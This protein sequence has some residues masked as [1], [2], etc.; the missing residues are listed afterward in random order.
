[1]EVKIVKNWGVRDVFLCSNCIL[2][3]WSVRH[4]FSQS[5][6]QSVAEPVGQ[7]VSQSV[8]YSVLSHS[9]SQ[10]VC[11]LLSQPISLSVSSPF[12]QTISQSLCQP[13]TTVQ[14]VIGCFVIHAPSC[15]SH[16][17]NSPIALGN[18]TGN[19]YNVVTAESSKVDVYVYLMPANVWDNVGAKMPTMISLMASSYCQGTAGHWVSHW[20]CK[21]VL[22]PWLGGC[23]LLL[24]H[25]L[26]QDDAGADREGQVLADCKG[27]D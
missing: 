1:M 9:V 6:N 25:P 15:A 18:T 7:S 12:R 16:F 8:G 17:G 23:L 14:T 3:G 20:T 19:W 2:C 26:T 10:S 11:Q 21:F 13:A 24:D 27:H 4:S 5:V 22:R